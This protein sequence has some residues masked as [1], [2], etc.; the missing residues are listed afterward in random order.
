[1]GESRLRIIV[2]ELLPN[3]VPVVASSFVSA[4]VYALGA[5]VGL[6]FLG[7]G[8]VERVT[9]GT[10]LYWARND[11]ALVTGSWWT[12]VPTGICVG[13]VGIG[14]ALLGSV[15]DRVANPR[16]RIPRAYLRATGGRVDAAAPTPILGRGAGHG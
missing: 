5:L 16:L 14:L 3:M 13:L 11:V 8:D 10:I 15:F 9:W 6:E 12:F 7:I 4:T 1:V 2:A